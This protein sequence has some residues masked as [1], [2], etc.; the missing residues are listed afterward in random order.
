[1]IKG[2]LMQDGKQRKIIDHK[3]HDDGD[4]GHHEILRC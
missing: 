2:T 3:Y 4:E 1:M